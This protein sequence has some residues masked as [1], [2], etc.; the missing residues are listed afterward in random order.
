MVTELWFSVKGSTYRLVSLLIV[1]KTVLMITIKG[2][3]KNSKLLYSLV[4]KTP[5]EK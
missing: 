4:K 2:M 1:K 3:A 5:T